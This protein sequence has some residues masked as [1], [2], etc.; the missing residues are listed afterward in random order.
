MEFQHELEVHAPVDAVYRF[1][2]DHARMPEWITTLEES[3][4]SAGFEWRAG[5]RFRQVHVEQGKRL[6]FEGVV[7]AAD[8]NRA[9]ELELEHPD[10]TLS[11]AYRFEETGAGTRFGQTSTVRL[12]SM[13]LRMMAKAFVPQVQA[14]IE[15]DV[16]QA[17]ALI[18]GE[19]RGS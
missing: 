11:V 3:V 15:R 13:M 18:E 14:R 10:A 4:P 9:L 5:E 7:K 16:E 8:E 2:T 17:K 6:E 1:V 12:K 19:S